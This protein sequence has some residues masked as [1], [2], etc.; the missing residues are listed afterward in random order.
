M[1]LADLNPVI[2]D[3]ILMFDCPN[4][5]HEH[6]IRIPIREDKAFKSNGAWWRLEGELPNVSA[7]NPSPG[8]QRSFDC[9]GCFHLTLDKGELK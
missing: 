7:F 8:A 2:K 4:P 1:K 3:G 6:K 5:E 9:E